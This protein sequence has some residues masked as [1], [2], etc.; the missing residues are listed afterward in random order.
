MAN[1]ENFL[2]LI[3]E[4]L[5]NFYYVKEIEIIVIPNNENLECTICGIVSKEATVSNDIVSIKT[6]I[7]EI[8][9]IALLNILELKKTKTDDIY[10]FKNDLTQSKPIRLYYNEETDLRLSKIKKLTLF[11]KNDYLRKN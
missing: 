2:L 10:I 11:N 6:T 1:N 7:E 4:Q 9:L 3:I 5:E 8:N